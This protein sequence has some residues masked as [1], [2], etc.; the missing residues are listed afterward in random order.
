RQVLVDDTDPAIHYGPSGW[1]VADPATLTRGN[2]GPIYN[3]TTRATSSSN[4][5]LIYSFNGT[6]ILV[7][8]T[9]DIS[10]DANNVT[11]PTWECFV[12]GI[13]IP[14]TSFGSQENNWPLC[15]QSNISPGPHI[16]SLQ[17]KSK[18]QPFYLDSLVY[19]PLPDAVFPSAVLIYADG[20]S[21]ISY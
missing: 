21:A 8:G 5:T 13:Q 7:Q 2:F 1:F 14:Q 10:T 17:V 16:L 4:S 19:T 20:D 3:D 9:I 12:D 18:G 11:D 6:S 15:E